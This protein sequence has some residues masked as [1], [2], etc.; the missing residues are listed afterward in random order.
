MRESQGRKV[1]GQIKVKHGI[2]TKWPEESEPA[3]I[4][5]WH[6]F[7]SSRCFP[8]LLNRPT[9]NRRFTVIKVIK[10]LTV[11]NYAGQ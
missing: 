11:T 2:F 5:S 3:K 1:W 7:G 10:P 9:N 6:K 4:Q 8:V